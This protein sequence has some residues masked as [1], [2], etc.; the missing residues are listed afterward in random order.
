V[1]P[2]TTH[3]AL[4]GEASIAYQVV[5]EGPID[6]VLVWG[7]MSHVE[8][9]WEDPFTTH[10]VNRLAAFSRVI[11]FDK[12]G[13]GL[14]DRISGQPTLEERMD[15]VRAVMDAVGSERAVI[16]GESEG[17]PMSIMFAATYPER[18]SHLVLYGSFARLVDASFPGAYAP[19]EYAAIIDRLANGWGHGDAMG[20]FAPSWARDFPDLVREEGGK[21]ERAAFS[22]GGFRQLMMMHGDIDARD[23]AATV[24]VPTLVLHRVGDQVIDVR[25]GRWLAAHIP[26]ARLVEL[27]GDDHMPSAG[28]ADALV[29][30]IE[31][32]LTGKQT[33]QTPERALA[34]VMFTDIVGSTAQAAAMG[35]A[36]WRTVLDQHEALVRRQLASHRGSEIKT[37]GDGF[38]ATFDGPARAVRCASEISRTVAAAGVQVRAGLHTGEVEL[39]GSDIGGIA[40]HI[41]SRIAGL[42]DGGQILTSRTVKDLVAGSGIRFTDLG[43]FTL[44]GVPDSWQVYEASLS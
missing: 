26:G 2:P 8:L 23:I 18:T 36:R 44:K 39:R 5:G 4:S 33:V 40:V 17:G 32:Y 11:M 34:T 6:L 1:A 7:T 21:F 15:D 3:Y 41:A 10:Y 13:C 28:D 29:D 20:W 25:Q 38:L 27:E 35:D 42:A 22:P 9:L 37:T 14:S 24:A 16:F 12:R 19:A 30:Q 43:E 31:E